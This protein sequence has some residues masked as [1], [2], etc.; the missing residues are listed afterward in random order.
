VRV[1]IIVPA[2]NEEEALGGLLS[3][4]RALPPPPD[5]TI[6]TVVV[7][8]G[9]HDRT[10]DVARKSGVR[11]L[12]LCGNLGI[13][14]AVQSGLRLAHREQFDAAIQ[15]DG[16][17]QHPPDQLATLI[18]T[19]KAETPPDL[20]IGTRYSDKHNFRSTVLRR[21]G[22]WWL[23]VIL[24]IVTRTKL[25]DPTSGF[26][27]YG[28]RALRLFDETYPYDYPE[29][30]SLAIAKAAGLSVVET[31]VSMRERQG[32]RSSIAGFS[33]IYYMLK[34]TIA[35]ALTYFRA[36]KRKIEDEDGS[37]TDR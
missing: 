11:V 18:A 34:V 16:D 6:D 2:F 37:S 19:V 10:T 22:S 21:L 8:D 28:P 13:G 36:R 1:L 25:S 14:G 17:G 20:V 32:G 26:R 31:R 30:E 5:V 33:T 15:M 9:S 24:R 12:R 23:K 35:V 27:L 29:P 3:E 4:L 7:D